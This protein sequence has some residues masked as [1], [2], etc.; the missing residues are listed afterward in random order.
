M[1]AAAVSQLIPR[2][3]DRNNSVETNGRLAR[4]PS[5]EAIR[6]ETS[7]HASQRLNPFE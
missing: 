6:P 7:F 5:I 3:L 1:P 4:W 2:T